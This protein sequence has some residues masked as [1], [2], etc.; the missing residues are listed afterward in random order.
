MAGKIMLKA[1]RVGETE[2]ESRVKLDINASVPELADIVNAIIGNYPEV[3]LELVEL[4]QT[5][6]GINV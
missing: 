5:G 2:T 1:T 3:A 4:K 6:G